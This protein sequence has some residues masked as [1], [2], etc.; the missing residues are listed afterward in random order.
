LTATLPTLA[1]YDS[2]GV[3]RFSNLKIQAAIDT[4]L[5]EATDADK[6]VIVAHHVYNTD[7]SVVENRTMMSAL[8]RLPAGFSV[9]AGGFKDWT[10]G[11]LGVEGK[12]VWKPQF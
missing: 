11:E 4:A 5:A 10:K 12:I 8:V 6:V 9:M 7:G 2:G 3:R 1:T